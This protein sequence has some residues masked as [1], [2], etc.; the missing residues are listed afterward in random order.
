MS[1]THTDLLLTIEDHE[2][3][4]AEKGHIATQ[5][6]LRALIDTAVHIAKTIDEVGS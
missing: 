4:L 2:V 1:T 3:V 6:G 5:G